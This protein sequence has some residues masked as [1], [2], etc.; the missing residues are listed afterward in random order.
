[1]QKPKL[2]QKKK[3]AIFDIDGTIFRSSL[4]IELVEELI[5]MEVF[6]EEVRDI[7]EKEKRAWLD[8]RGDYESYVNATVKAFVQNLIGVRYRDLEWAGKRVVDRMGFQVYRHTTDLVQLLKKKGYYLVA[9]SHSPKIVVDQF[10]KRLGFNKVYGMMYE[11]GP[12]DAFTGKIL[13]S[14]VIGNKANVVE[15]AVLKENLTLKGSYGVGDT[16]TDISFLSMVDRPL[17]FNPN[18]KLLKH[19]TKKK[20]SVVVER[21]DVVYKF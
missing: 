20:W 4:L 19:A 3:V 14:H 12:N 9:I 18:K 16:E 15:R 6:E 21:K 17:A 2:M 10:A 8:R 1:M 13:D 5:D 7:Y 11:I